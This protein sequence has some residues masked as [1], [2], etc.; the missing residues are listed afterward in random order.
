MESLFVEVNVL[1]ILKRAKG[2][3]DGEVVPWSESEDNVR[4]EVNRRTA[5]AGYT[6][7]YGEPTSSGRIISKPLSKKG[8]E[9]YVKIFGH[10]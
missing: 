4:E 1:E 3:A 8:R 6:T 5:K 7:K 9:N 10:K 2:K